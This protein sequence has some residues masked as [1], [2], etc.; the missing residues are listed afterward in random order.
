MPPDL[1]DEGVEYVVHMSAMGGRGFDEFAP[2]LVGQRG[3]LVR[4]DPPLTAVLKV[5]LVAHQDHR[6]LVGGANLFREKK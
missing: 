6:H 5:N 4:A 1:P 2:E 3:P